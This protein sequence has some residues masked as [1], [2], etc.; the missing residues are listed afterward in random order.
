MLVI[1]LSLLISVIIHEVAHGYVANRL[2]DPTARLQGRLTLNPIAHLDWLG[3]VLLPGMM[4]VLGAPFFIGWAKPVPVNP[5]YFKD[6][7][8]DMM[9]VAL[10]GPASNL[11]LALAGSVMLHQGVALDTAFIIRQ[12]ITINSVLMMFNLLPIPPLDGSRVLAH[13]MPAWR[14]QISR[15]EPYGF[16]IIL[17]LAYTGILSDV[18]RVILPPVLRLV[19]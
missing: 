14:Q 18:L 19:L 9:I 16:V 7:S 17:V 1:I 6:P 4:L 3:S 2:G 15:L 10:A 5:R 11:C 13:V 8:R 12:F